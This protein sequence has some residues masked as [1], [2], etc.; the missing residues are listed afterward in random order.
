MPAS[1]R[2]VLARGTVAVAITAACLGCTP[3]SPD[4]PPALALPPGSIG[5]IDVPRD[6]LIRGSSVQISGWVADPAGIDRV[7]LRVDGRADGSSDGADGPIIAAHYGVARADVAALRPGYPDSGRAGFEISA[8]LGALSA[9]RHTL[10]V[11]AVNRTGKEWIVGTRGLVPPQAMSVWQPLYAARGAAALP[12]FDFLIGA[13][14]VT[15][16]DADELPNY[17]RDYESPTVGVGVRVPILYLRTTRGAAGDWVFDPDWN[18]DRRCGQRRI[19]DD[20]LASV[21]RYSIDHQLPVLLTLNGG[22]WADASCD[23]P[24]WDVNDHLEQDAA[25]CQWNEHDGVEPDDALKHLPGG[26][27]APEL[28]RSL[29]FNVHAAKNRAYKRRNLQAAGRIIAAFAREHP[30]LFA[31]V[32]LD[33]DT[34]LNPF[35]EEREWYDYN[36][37]TLRQ[38]R[39]WLSGSGPYAGKRSSGVP[40][41]SRYRRKRVLS[42]QEVSRLA[43][44]PFARW[45]D[46]DP[47]R[48][49]ERGPHPFWKD[50]W[51][52]EWDVF[53]RHLVA[54][55]Y[56]ELAQWLREVGL[57]REKIFS[58]QGFMAPTGDALPLPVKLDSP[59]KNYDGGGMSIEGSIPRN[60][61]LGAILYGKSAVDDVLMETKESLFTTFRRMDE[62]WAVV[63][64]NTGD[65][66]APGALPT[67]AMGYRALRNMFNN[68]ARFASPMAWNGSNGVFAGQ[69]DYV[70]YTAWRN[71]PLEEAMRDFAVSHAW[72]PLGARLWTFG[73]AR[74]ADDD[75][76]FGEAGTRLSAGRGSLG[77]AA[78]GE[79]ASLLS[80]DDLVLR[81]GSVDALVLQVEDADKVRSIAVEA[82]GEGQAW[83]VL[84]PR[85]PPAALGRSSAGWVVPLSWPRGLKEARRLRLRIGLSMHPAHIKLRHIALYPRVNS[86]RAVH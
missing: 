72:V 73:T 49:F 59:S 48:V 28:G 42:L 29:T 64:F 47:P 79:D 77:V 71:T 66:R 6:E 18:V 55:H 11:V 16:G 65:L 43:G 68:G 38:F 63:E 1:F 85:T 53:R 12:A 23:V 62:G 3:R 81:P 9:E 41:L 13:S 26:M 19:A 45:S 57:P 39:E 46:V 17:Y 27:A 83:S 50:P 82:Q 33:P 31:G 84:A 78:S 32:N 25:N 30:R 10:S 21:L 35:F 14:G 2:G 54:L 44:R 52:H 20:S 15:R 34:Y 60:G 61:H 22:I 67:Y 51:T 40:D 58:S 36:P 56:D 70:P 80:P 74:L 76:W 75:A 37:G 69:P 5:G 4:T 86:R 24:D 8:D 7:E